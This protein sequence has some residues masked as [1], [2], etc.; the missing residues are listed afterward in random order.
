MQDAFQDR[1]DNGGPQPDLLHDFL[2]ILRHQS[3]VTFGQ[4]YVNQTVTGVCVICH[5]LHSIHISR[6]TIAPPIASFDS[7]DFWLGGRTPKKSP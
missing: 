2:R 4:Q 6:F 1:T 5:V 7:P 3:D